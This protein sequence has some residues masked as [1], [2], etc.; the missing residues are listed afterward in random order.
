LGD[1]ED[2]AEYDG[3]VEEAGVALDRLQG[4]FRREGGCPADFEEG[5]G[6]ANF[7]KFFTGG[8]EIV[9]GLIQFTQGDMGDV[10]GRYRPA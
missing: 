2:V 7:E 3:R 6:F 8:R 10:P 4:D 1:D 9:S 5:M